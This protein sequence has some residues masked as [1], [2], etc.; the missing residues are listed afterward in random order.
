MKMWVKKQT[1]Q[2]STYGD[3]PSHG[4]TTKSSI[5]MGFSIINYKVSIYQAG[6]SISEA[7]TSST[8]VQRS[9]CSQL[10]THLEKSTM[11]SCLGH[12]TLMVLW[13]HLQGLRMIRT[14]PVKHAVHSFNINLNL[15]KFVFLVAGSSPHLVYVDL[16]PHKPSSLLEIRC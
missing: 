16:N 15:C 8:N 10:T 4:G 1:K 2:G 5:C 12:C 11:D 3:F 13:K 6:C 7:A 14:Q 9:Q